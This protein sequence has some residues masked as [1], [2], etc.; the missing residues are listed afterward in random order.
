MSDMSYQAPV[1]LL[2]TVAMLILAYSWICWRQKVASIDK[3]CLVLLIG[4]QENFLEGL[5]RLFFLRCQRRKSLWRLRV[6]AERPSKVT[7]AI[8][9]HLLVPYSCA[10]TALPLPGM[11]DEGQ[12]AAGAGN[13]VYCL[14]IREEKSFRG[15]WQRLE[16]FWQQNNM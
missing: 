4:D 10:L 11:F 9:C 12:G 15:A 5:L 13:K 14:D 16:Q 3:P 8:L 7:L 6:I 2:A 1:I